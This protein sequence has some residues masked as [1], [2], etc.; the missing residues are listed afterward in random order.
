[1]MGAGLCTKKRHDAGEEELLRW[2]KQMIDYLILDNGNESIKNRTEIKAGNEWDD[3]D[4]E[5]NDLNISK[6]AGSAREEIGVFYSWKHSKYLPTVSPTKT[7]GAYDENGQ[8]RTPVLSLGEVVKSGKNLPSGRNHADYIQHNGNYDVVSFFND[9]KTNFPHLSKVVIGQLAPHITT[10]VDCESLFSQAG[11]LSHP[12]RNRTVA[13][14][15][16]HMTMAKHCLNRIYCDREKV[17]QEFMMRWRNKQFSEKEDR[18]DIEFWE[19]QKQEY[20]DI[21]PTHDGLFQTTDEDQEG[22]F[23][24]I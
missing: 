19:Q 5:Y 17:K 3:S 11:H 12:N 4:N 22:Q 10:E 6:A 7:L 13:E 14:T 18:D 8:P 9:H 20:L 1:M 15:F 2:I 21:N 16:E 23:Q 24:D